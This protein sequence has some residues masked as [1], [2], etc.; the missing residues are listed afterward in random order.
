MFIKYSLFAFPPLGFL[1]LFYPRH[2]CQMAVCFF[3]FSPMSFIVLPYIRVFGIF[4][5]MFLYIVHSKLPT[6]FFLMRKSV[7]PAC[8]LKVLASPLGRQSSH[9]LRTHVALWEVVS[10]LIHSHCLVLM[11]A[12][13][14]LTP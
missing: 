8:L 12:S 6:S 14:A 4:E 1:Y 3:S 2:G 5:T 7:F 11:E 9:P 10:L 13:D